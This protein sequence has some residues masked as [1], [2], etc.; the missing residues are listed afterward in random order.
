VFP[1]L[2]L[3]YLLALPFIVPLVISSTGALSVYAVDVRMVAP[4]PGHLQVYYDSGDGFSEARS[5][6]IELQQG[7]AARDYRVPLSSG[8]C[9][10]LRIDPGTLGGDYVIE[11]V[12]V[13]EPDEGIVRREIPLDAFR[14]GPGVTL[15]ASAGRLTVHA[16]P[17]LSDPQ[18]YYT[19]TRPLTLPRPWINWRVMRLLGQVALWWLA[20]TGVVW[21]FERL[22]RP[23]HASVH[24]GVTDLT[25]AAERHPRWAISCVAALAAVISMYPVIVLG[26]SL[27]TP[28]NGFVR[29]LYQEAPF[30]P[31]SDDTAVED[32]RGSD[33]G[34]TMVHGIPHTLMEREALAQGEMPLWNRYHSAG[35]PLWSQGL[36]FLGDPLHWLTIVVPD[37]GL[38]WDLKFLAHRFLFALGVGVA[39]L[40]ATNAL[41]PALLVAMGAPFVGVYAFRFNHPAAFVLTYA[42]WILLGWFHLAHASNRRQM[43]RAILWLAVGSCLVLLSSTPKEAAMMLLGVHGAGVLTVLITETT[44]VMRLQRI[45]AASI[46]GLA[47]I[48]IT[49]PHW[50][51]FLD[52]LQQSFT[53]YDTPQAVLAD[54]SYVAGMFLSPVIPGIALPGLHLLALVLLVACLMRPRALFEHRAVLACAVVGLSCIGL[55]FGAVP[56]SLLV[57]IPFVK[58]IIH[59]NDVFITMA[60]P[61]L[62]IAA[63]AGVLVFGASLRRA[64]VT[65]LIVGLF[66]AWVYAGY[67]R[68]S[69]DDA[70]VHWAVVLLIPLAMSVPMAFHAAMARRGRLMPILASVLAAVVIV[71]PGGMHAETGLDTLDTLLLQPRERANLLATSPVVDA[72]HAGMKDPVRATGLDWT[73]H[74]GSQRYYGLE[75]IGGPDPL[76]IASYR[77]LQDAAHIRRAMAWFTEISKDEA[78]RFGTLLDI[79]NVGY[80][81]TRADRVP[82]GFDPVPLSGPDRNLVGRRSSVWPRAFFVDG[83][84]SHSDAADF[85]RQAEAAGKPMGAV[86]AGDERALEMVRSYI[87]PSGTMIPAQDYRLT[88]NTTSFHLRVPSAGVAVLG[89]TFLAEDFRATVNGQP[90]PYF[91]VNQTFKGVIVPGAGDW[92]VRFEYR[93]RHWNASLAMAGIGIALLVLIGIAAGRPVSAPSSPAARSGI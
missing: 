88:V 54:R 65:A 86:Q 39:V 74:S 93:P 9:A 17:G 87:K 10:S 4:A 57:K 33:V 60:V 76:M 49:T 38:G 62:L 20:A 24:R 14:A 47:A 15:E 71:L 2:L 40:A 13:V 42:P 85:L 27:V 44:W 84:S 22:S 70:F 80:L 73:L 8:R 48:L 66:L 45:A 21:A 91:R 53:M 63:A 12:A 11:R 52:T 41:L 67:R 29:L 92:D 51:N 30:T 43:A 59:V 79:L 90:A 34:A 78:P 69:R 58:N 77:D 25:A 72:I 55:A 5:A 36:A 83:V 19:P 32:T 3:G 64:W 35:L 1:R 61:P 46:A 23:L 26:K 16:P 82:I 89:E 37:P 68:I 31:G 7:T 75:G 56:A 50:W 28:N 6:A 81:V 18:I